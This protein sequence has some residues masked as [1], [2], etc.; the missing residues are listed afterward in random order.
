MPWKNNYQIKKYKGSD[1]ISK[2]IIYMY[3][4]P[5]GKRYIGKTQNSLSRR[6]GHQWNRYKN[7]QLLWRA[8]QKYGTENI[9]TEILFE[10]VLT[11]EEASEKERF[12]IAQFKT[13]ANRYRNPQ[14]GYNLTDGGDGLVGWHPTEERYKQMMEQLE[15]ANE[16]RLKQ[17]VS[18]ESRKKMSESHKGLRTGYKMP[19]ETKKK[20]GIANSL[21]NI[22][23]ETRRRKSKAHMKPVIAI[24]KE[25]GTTIIFN[26][27][28][29]V[30]EYFGVRE[31]AVTRWIDGTR[32]PSVPYKFDNYSPT[33]TERAEVA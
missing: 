8:I 20:I 5:N 9:K 12:F 6:Q 29:E 32:N 24:N 14:Y 4:F 1:N 27:R 2:Y 28:S 13:N 31:S 3:V 25:D 26:S 22:S 17:G 21:E 19:E 11:D 23:E 30:A 15:K 10:G 7:C 16:V 18:E 33:T